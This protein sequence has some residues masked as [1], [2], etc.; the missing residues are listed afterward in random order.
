MS[1]TERTKR[2]SDSQSDAGPASSLPPPFNWIANFIDKYFIRMPRPVQVGV[3]VV[4][5]LYFLVGSVKLFAPEIWDSVWSAD[6]EIEGVL[7]GSGGNVV[8]DTVGQY[9]L[10]GQSLFVTKDFPN[11][12]V[13][14]ECEF[15][16]ILKV[17]RQDMDQQRTF[18]LM[19]GF[20]E[21]GAI[22]T[23]PRT[24][25]NHRTGNEVKLALTE[26][27]ATVKV[28]IDYLDTSGTQL[29]S[30]NMFS[31]N[32]LFPPAWYGRV[33]QSSVRP[34]SVGI[35]LER[36]TEPKYARVQLQIRQLLTN[37]GSDV[38]KIV[39]DSL[40][41]ALLGGRVSNA[42][43]YA[44]ALSDFD[45]LALF[46]ASP[47]YRKIFADPF[48]EKA[49][50]LIRTGDQLQSNYMATLLH[51]LQDAR[52]T[53]YVIQAFQQSSSESAQGLCLYV[54]GAFSANSSKE[55]KSS[56]KS[57]LQALNASNLS[58]TIRDA[59]GQTIQKF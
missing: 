54:I 12:M 6:I 2:N 29:S 3:F 20:L 40:R 31:G 33:Q 34:D 15:H 18:T 38:M 25:L 10:S 53:K 42:G 35:L 27:P 1:D 51:N 9:S 37:G 43:L 8:V 39:A 58:Q 59:L 46:S 7:T 19:D 22:R 50:D 44:L 49:A 5:V 41:N 24:L 48:Y 45:S 57:Q 55:L 26:I 52:S 11:P 14:T 4:F 28:K 16:W 32:L 23:T 47:L 17:P 36:L 13:P 21:K 30:M 56:I